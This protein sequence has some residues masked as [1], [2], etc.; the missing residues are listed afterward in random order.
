MGQGSHP[1]LFSI[2]PSET[3]PQKFVPAAI[4]LVMGIGELVGGVVMP[5][6]A[7]HLADTVSPD[8]PFIMCSI[9]AVIGAVVAFALKETA[10]AKSKKQ[11]VVG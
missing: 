9:V 8:A 4:G 7:G 1:A 5:I 6:L 2:I 10:P 11:E 3:V